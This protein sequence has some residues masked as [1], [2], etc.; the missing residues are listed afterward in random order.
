MA[1]T[2]NLDVKGGNV[3]TIPVIRG[4]NDISLNEELPPKAAAKR[5]AGHKT[6]G[7]MAAAVIMNC[8]NTAGKFCCRVY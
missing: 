6:G 5:I 4:L 8:N 2:G 7:E 1:I 3:I